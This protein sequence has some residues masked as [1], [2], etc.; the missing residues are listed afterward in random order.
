MQNPLTLRVHTRHTI[1]LLRAESS[2]GKSISDCC[3]QICVDPNELSTLVMCNQRKRVFSFDQNR[4]D[5]KL[6]ELDWK[7][8]R[9]RYAAE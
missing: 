4:F 1:F 6:H 9:R 8:Q 5:Y 3:A 7:W 2:V